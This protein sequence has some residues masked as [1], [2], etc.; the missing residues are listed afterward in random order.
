ME[1]FIKAAEYMEIPVRRSDDEPLQKLFSVVKGELNL[2]GKNAKQEQAKYWKQHPSL[3]KTELLIQAHLTRKAET[4]SPDLQRDYKHMLQLAPRLLEELFVMA[5]LP[6]TS[7]GHGW[8]R[9][10]IG[11]VELSQCIVQVTSY[12]PLWEYF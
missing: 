6:R 5:N 3:I 4:L 9:P 12:R 10:A 2:D 11:V 8:L 7:K 1:V